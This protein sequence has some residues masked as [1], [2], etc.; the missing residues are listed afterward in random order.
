LS[1]P[2]ILYLG[3]IELFDLFSR[4]P[5][6]RNRC[7]SAPLAPLAPKQAHEIEY[8]RTRRD[9]ETNDEIGGHRIAA[10]AQPALNL[11]PIIR[12]EIV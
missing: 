2:Y 5:L 1:P 6:D 7:A 12:P 11:D 8:L 4:V 3:I 10:L 9:S